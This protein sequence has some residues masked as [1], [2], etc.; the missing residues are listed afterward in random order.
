MGMR[1]AQGKQVSKANAYR[2]REIKFNTDF[3]NDVFQ[4]SSV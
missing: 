2:K 4:C 1:R 3:S